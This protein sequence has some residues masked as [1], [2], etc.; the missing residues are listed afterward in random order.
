[1][2]SLGDKE[3]ARW[4]LICSKALRRETARGGRGWR[5]WP[6]KWW[7]RTE[8]ALGGGT[9]WG[10]SPSPSPLPSS[11]EH[12]APTLPPC[13]SPSRA[14]STSPPPPRDLNTLAATAPPR[15]DHRIL[16]TASL[17]PS[18]HQHRASQPASSLCLL[19]SP[20]RP[21]CHRGGSLA[22]ATT[23]TQ[24]PPRTTAPS[25]WP[26]PTQPR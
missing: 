19:L 12:P 23:V 1:M 24:H 10:S 6:E 18:N 21:Q 15:G 9:R 17:S 26:P 8:R 25:T 22:T 16:E 13:T 5:T 7:G 2:K 11:M 4:G 3:G 20:W 14:P